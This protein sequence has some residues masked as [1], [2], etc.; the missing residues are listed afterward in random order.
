[1][2]ADSAERRNYV[3]L[4]L[5]CAVELIDATNQAV[6]HGRT[7]N[8]SN[9]GALVRIPIGSAP[10]LGSVVEMKMHVPHSRDGTGPT[11]EFSAQVRIL[12][13]EQEADSDN[14]AVAMQFLEPLELGLQ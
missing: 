3:R 4:A 7:I 12:R 6:A 8:I 5:T 14:T 13:C 1:M 9:G 11:R 2:S 10:S